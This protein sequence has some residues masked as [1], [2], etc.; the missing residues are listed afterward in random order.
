MLLDAV[1]KQFEPWQRADLALRRGPR[2]RDVLPQAFVKT[3]LGCEMLRR[4]RKNGERAHTQRDGPPQC[5]GC[6]QPR[7]RSLC[8]LAVGP[9]GRCGA[10]TQGARTTFVKDCTTGPF[11]LIWNFGIR[12]DRPPRSIDGLNG[13]L[14]LDR[15][16]LPGG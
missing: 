14:Y 7:N 15:V 12:S 13:P 2:A 1:Q 6:N 10:L 3:P 11:C 9:I 4:S 16:A 8:P 5:T